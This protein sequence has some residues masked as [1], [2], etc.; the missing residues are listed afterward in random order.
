MAV[1]IDR[2][3]TRVESAVGICNQRLRLEYHEML[4]T[5]TFNRKLRR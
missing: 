2:N 1:Q 3:R 5:F 4:S